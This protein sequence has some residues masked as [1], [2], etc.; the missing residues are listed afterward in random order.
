MADPRSSPPGRRERRKIETRQRLFRAAM[1]LFQEKGFDAT[2]IDEIAERADVAKGTVFNYFPQKTAFLTT[3][4]Q[5]WFSRMTEEMGP[6]SSWR[7]GTRT[8]LLRVFDYLAGLADRHRVLAR[9]ILFENM[10]QAHLAMGEPAPSGDGVES[11][12][13]V[14]VRLLEGLVREVLE[15]GRERGDVREDADLEVAP[16]LIAGMAFHT[17]VRGLVEGGPEG[18]LE[19]ALAARLDIILTGLAP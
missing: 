7:T 5:L 4:Y 6:V 15:R 13:Q 19:R 9:L 18:N 10:R 14:G 3:S 16:D 12:S 8:S 1:E 11:P 2:T 17:L